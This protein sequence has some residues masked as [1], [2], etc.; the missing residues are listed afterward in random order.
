MNGIIAVS[1]MA[2]ANAYII[3]ETRACLEPVYTE[4]VERELSR[5]Q[6]ASKECG[7][8]LS[9]LIMLR[10]NYQDFRRHHRWIEAGFGRGTGRN[11]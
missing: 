1:G 11:S 3:R 4:D 6:A 7:R 2:Y 9:D 8:Q 5:L 10:E